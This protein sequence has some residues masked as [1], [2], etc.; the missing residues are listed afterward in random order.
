[1]AKILLVEDE[2]ELAD[3]IVEWLTEDLHIVESIQ[4]GGE[5]INR[6]AKTDYDLIILDLMLPNIGG[7]EICRAYRA[8]GG[9]SPILILTARKSLSLKE[10]GLDSGADD[11]LT[12]P[13]K[14]RELAA[15][16][17]ALLRRPNKVLPTLLTI[18]DLALNSSTHEVTIGGKQVHLLPKEICLLELLMRNSGEVL[19]VDYLIEKAW[20][21]DSDVS[22]DTIRS[23]VRSLRKKLADD[24]HDSLIQNVHGMGYKIGMPC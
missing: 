18:G 16:I 15:R 19:S 3:I 10:A 17:R 14:L 22:P 7:L 9:S 13:F 2:Q 24:E 5:A 6:L 23:H 4:D 20:P 8:G 11:Y 12:K 21:D 1:M